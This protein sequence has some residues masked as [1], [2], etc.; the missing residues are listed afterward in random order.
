[1][2][3]N[4]I[5]GLIVG[6][7]YLVSVEVGIATTIAVIIHEVPQEIGDFGVLVHGGFSK[8]KALMLNFLTALTALLG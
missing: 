8:R 2:F 5:D 3:H 1:M 7:S 4:F 6:A